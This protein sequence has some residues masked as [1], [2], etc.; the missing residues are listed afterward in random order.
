MAALTNNGEWWSPSWTVS[1]R[2]NVIKD[3]G[4]QVT[5][6]LAPVDP[7]PGVKRPDPVDPAVDPTTYW[8]SSQLPDLFA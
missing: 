1:E 5:F 2:R 4:V 6:T 3:F 8:K 7:A